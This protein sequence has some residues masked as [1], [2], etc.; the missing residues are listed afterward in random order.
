MTTGLSLGEKEFYGDF[1]GVINDLVRLTFVK[2]GTGRT[3]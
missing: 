3:R 1:G 2:E